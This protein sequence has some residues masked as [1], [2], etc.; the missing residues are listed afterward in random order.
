VVLTGGTAQ[1]PAALAV[2]GA[3]AGRDEGLAGAAER[4]EEADHPADVVPSAGD[5]A[6]ILAEDVPTS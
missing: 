5:W 2:A 1:D 4:L 6:L 3:W